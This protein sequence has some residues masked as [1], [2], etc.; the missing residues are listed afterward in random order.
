[1]TQSTKGCLHDIF[2]S[3]ALEFPD[4]VAV[5]VAGE[6]LT[7]AEL[8]RMS[9]RVARMLVKAGIAPDVPVGLCMD[10]SIEMVVAMLAILK[11]GG[12]YV[13]IDPAYPQKRIDFLLKDSGVGVVAAVE[14]VRDCLPENPGAKVICID[15]ER[16]HAEEEPD[17]FVQMSPTRPENLAYVIYT[18]GSTGKP[19]GVMVEHR[20]A[21]RLFEQTQAWF[22]FSETDVWTMFHSIGFDFSVWEIWGAL[23]HGGELVI[24]PYDISRSPAQFRD[25][26]LQ[27]KVT[28]LNQ[29]PSAFMQLISADRMAAEGA[30]F[31]LRHVIF[32]GEKLDPAMLTPWVARY[33]DD[34]PALINMYGLTETTVHVTYRRIL[35]KDLK[36]A[37]AS[38]IGC[39]IPDLRLELLD[40]SMQ[41]VPDSVPGELYIGGAGVARGYLRRP[42]L[43]A[44]R[45]VDGAAG[46][47]YRT[48]DRAIRMPNGEYHY[49]GRVDDQM[50]VRG[51]RIE[52][53]EIEACLSAHVRVAAC[54][55]A[56]RDYG[57]GDVRLAAYVVPT[58]LNDV[59]E[60]NARRLA[61]EMARHAASQLPEY[62]RPSSFVCLK[63]LPLTEHGKVDRAILPLPARET[64]ANAD[65][66]ESLSPTEQ[67]VAGICLE[68][69]KVD[70][71]GKDVDLFDAGATSLTL[72]RIFAQIA[73]RLGARPPITQFTDGITVAALVQAVDEEC[74]STQFAKVA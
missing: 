19:K 28:V 3:R 56:C 12:A 44:A 14:R 70:S 1:M 58:D 51:F 32:G 22:G 67:A 8:D 4:R 9:D 42:E 25:L 40:E 69:L 36:S 46:R 29:T 59:Q 45:F 13:P 50:K 49:C 2:R 18:S 54:V 10:R 55:V 39:P 37:S 26:L 74:R 65:A 57:E 64:P 63:E 47:M 21:V 73:K 5:S 20:N 52:P 15:L 17:T 30:Q 16:L 68:I 38:P 24:V 62:M 34:A 61:L 27:R 66:T 53:G 41:P 35:S 48:G 11:A 6:R 43:T 7:Y 60:P 23:L 31:S 33:G 71:L 72:M